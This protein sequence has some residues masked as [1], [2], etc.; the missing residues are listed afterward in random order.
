VNGAAPLKV[1]IEIL[2]VGGE[3]GAALRA[4]QARVI[5]ELLLWVGNEQNDED[6]R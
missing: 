2:T 6:E 1:S 3:E 4:A 5:H